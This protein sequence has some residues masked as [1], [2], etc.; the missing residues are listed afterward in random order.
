MWPGRSKKLDRL[1]LEKF[2]FTEFLHLNRAH[3]M[4]NFTISDE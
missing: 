3:K 4:K 1:V 2:D